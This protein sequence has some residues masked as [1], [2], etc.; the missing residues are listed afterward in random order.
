MGTNTTVAELESAL[1]A[2]WS[3]ET[4]SDPP[5]WSAANPAWGQCAVT[6]LVVQDF[7]GGRLIRGEV[8]GISHYLNVLPSGREL[9]FTIRQFGPTSP[10]ICGVVERTREYVLSFAETQLRYRILSQR[11]RIALAEPATKES[12]GGTRLALRT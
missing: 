2:S 4:S 10:K 11:V 6:A 5:S 12:A 1:A 8:G 3:P 7:L 9:D